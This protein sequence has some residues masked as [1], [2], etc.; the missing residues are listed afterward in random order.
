MISA[1]LLGPIRVLLGSLTGGILGKWITGLG[2]AAATVQVIG[3][4]RWVLLIP[5]LSD[6]AT[7]P[8]LAE[9]AH[10]T[11]DILHFRLGTITGETVGY[12]LTATFI[13]LA[14]GVVIPLRLS[15]A[16]I[17]NFVGY[18]AWCLW[19]IVRFDHGVG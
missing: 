11:F 2:I 4:S 6:N 16:G 3:L 18:V 14:T 7:V 10:R 19:L 9:S 13:V 1:A 5:G 12:A 8:A 15:G 17:S